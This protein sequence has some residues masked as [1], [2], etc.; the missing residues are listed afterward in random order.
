MDCLSTDQAFFMFMG[1]FST[2][3]IFSSLF[4]GKYIWEPMRKHY[5]KYK[6]PELPYLYKY[7]LDE[8]EEETDNLGDMIQNVLVEHTPKGTVFMRYNEEIEGFE[9]W[10]E[11]SLGYLILDTVARKYV[12]LFRCANAYVEQSEEEEKEEEEDEG[13]DD[14][15]FV[16]NKKIK[17]KKIVVV[18]NK[19]VYKGEWKDAPFFQKEEEKKTFFCGS[20]VQGLNFASFKNALIRTNNN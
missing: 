13:E 8:E 11:K 10:S 16:K 14:D 5:A 3:L 6:I 4:V 15:L 18:S 2:S 9:Y 19:F 7:P 12:L 17:K 1:L 20:E